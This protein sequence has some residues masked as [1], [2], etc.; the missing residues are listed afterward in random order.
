MTKV[1]GGRGTVFGQRGVGSVRQVAGDRMASAPMGWAVVCRASGVRVRKWVMGD[2]LG[3]S[4][5]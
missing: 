3:L 1:E 2:L 4:G 5:G